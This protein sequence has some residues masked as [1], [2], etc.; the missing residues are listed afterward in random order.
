MW[1]DMRARGRV[2][3][4]SQCAMPSGR[5]YFF[6]SGLPFSRRLFHFS[7]SEFDEE[8]FCSMA[9]AQ[10]YTFIFIFIGLMIHIGIWHRE[11]CDIVVCLLFRFHRIALC[12]RIESRV[13]IIAF[14]DF[15]AAF[16]VEMLPKTHES[17]ASGPKMK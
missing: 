3:S 10:S 8:N 12:H 15:A 9:A 16:G 17:Q 11:P 1:W 4:S 2:K 6:S 13:F 7:V 5:I 14:D